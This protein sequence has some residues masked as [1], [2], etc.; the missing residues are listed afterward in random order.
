VA[1]LVAAEETGALS[2]AELVA[3]ADWFG[4]RRHPR[5]AG[6]IYYGGPAVPPWVDDALRDMLGWQR[7]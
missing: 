3:G 1:Y 6:T 5:P 7:P 4:I 2:G